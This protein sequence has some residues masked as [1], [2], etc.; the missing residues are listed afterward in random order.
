M[1]GSETVTEFRPCV[2]FEDYE[3]SEIGVVRNVKTGY[4]LTP[5]LRNGYPSVSIKKRDC[6]VHRLV[7]L[8][9]LPPPKEGQTQVNH[10]FPPKS[11][12]CASNLEWATPSENNKHAYDTGLISKT[13]RGRS[14]E[15]VDMEGNVVQMYCSVM[16]AGRD[17]GVDAS[18]ISVAID[19]PE[20]TCKGFRWRT[21][22]PAEL[23][24]EEWVD[25]RRAFGLSFAQPYSVS[26]LGRMKGPKG[27]MH[28]SR[29]NDGYL[30]QHLYCFA[31][32][33][34][35][36][37]DLKVSRCVATAFLGPAP[38][39]HHVVD[40][41]DTNRSNDAHT[42]LRW[43]T[44]TENITFARGRPVVQLSSDGAVIAKFDSVSLAARIVKRQACTICQ[45]IRLRGT[46]A[47]SHWAY[48]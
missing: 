4:V 2:G 37:I 36:P 45:A 27:I 21:S 19:R 29:D 23:L 48:A 14:V 47:G 42:N 28:G 15:S 20:R 18:S 31:D 26:S 3:I 13:R 1:A 5:Y 24:G 35:K 22:V 10:K 11:N 43:V 17:L 25:F 30:H 44:P 46:S 6:R 12:C 16:E 34:S 7:A 9:W 8:A 33:E 32:G 40:H 41:I 39:K 38:S